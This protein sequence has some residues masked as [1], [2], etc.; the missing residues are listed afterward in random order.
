MRLFGPRERD[1]VV[2]YV[3]LCL[4]GREF[5]VFY[6]GLFLRER[7]RVVFYLGLRFYSNLQW[8][9]ASGRANL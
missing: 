3:G 5:V 6:V 2:I 9:V 4:R 7:E 8:I 1:I